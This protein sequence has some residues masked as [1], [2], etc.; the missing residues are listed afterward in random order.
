MHTITSFTVNISMNI[1]PHLRLFVK[2]YP[3]IFFKK[4]KYSD[5]AQLVIKKYCKFVDF[6]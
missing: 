2:V 1:I 3:N 4:A 5:V 6:F